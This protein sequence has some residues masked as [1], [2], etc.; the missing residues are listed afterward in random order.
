MLFVTK[1]K[2][3]LVATLRYM[4]QLKMQRLAATIQHFLFYTLHP[5]VPG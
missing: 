4:Y 3:V 2:Q 5:N 1:A